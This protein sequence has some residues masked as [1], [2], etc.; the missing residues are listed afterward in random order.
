VVDGAPDGIDAGR[1][2]VAA[3]LAVAEAP[4]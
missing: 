2:T 1:V 3:G 4:A